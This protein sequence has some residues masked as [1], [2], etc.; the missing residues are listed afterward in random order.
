MGIPVLSVRDRNG[1]EISIPAIKG[2]KGDSGI[3]IGS[4][5]MPAG[6]NVQIDPNG[7]AFELPE[8][9]QI[10]NPESKNAQSGI[11]VAEALEPINNQ[12]ELIETITLEEAVIEITRNAEPN[13]KAYSFKDIYIKFK[14]V[15]GADS[16]QAVRA[17]IYSDARNAYV[18]RAIT[19]INNSISWI[20]TI[21]QNGQRLFILSD[22]TTNHGYGNFNAYIPVLMLESTK[23]IDEITIGHATELRAGTKIEIWGVRA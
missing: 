2:D 21:Y 10:Y 15:N 4:D 16:N 12:F 8:T 14:W 22:A 23:P 9:D 18:F 5:D 11:A 3:Y 19:P 6:Y 20:K 17:T 1:N 13:G 7:S